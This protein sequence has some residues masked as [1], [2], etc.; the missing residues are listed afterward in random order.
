MDEAAQ[1][2]EVL[3]LCDRLGI[4]IRREHLGGDGGNL[5]S[6]RG[7]RLLFVDLDAD[8]ATR[9]EASLRALARL[10]EL[11]TVYVPQVLRELIERMP[12]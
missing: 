1:F 10:P 2:D 8:S 11:E 6:L 12:K 5:C 3:K 9:L 7:R 4:E